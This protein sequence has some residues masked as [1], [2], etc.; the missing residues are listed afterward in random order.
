MGLL[1]SIGSALS[2][3]I[4]SVCSMA[5]SAIGSI[6]SSISSFAT[7]IAPKLVTVLK[8]APGVISTVINVAQTIGILFNIFKPED[9]VEDLG[10]KAIQAADKGIT[11]D[12][13]DDNDDY[14]DALR[15]FQT[16]PER[17]AEIDD[18]VKT[19]A[20]LGLVTTGIEK[21]LD[22]PEGSTGGI[23]LLAASAPEHF[24]AERLSNMI[25]NSSDLSN[26][27][28]YFDGDLNVTDAM[29]IEKQLVS[30]EQ[31]FSPELSVQ[32]VNEQLDSVSDT[33][34]AFK[35]DSNQ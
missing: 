11:I 19:V 14:M 8:M 4:S 33:V 20:G 13:Y 32:Q 3:G 5:S 12:D 34:Q 22:L 16:D 23:F 31:V 26:V 18:V 9:R 2:S 6:G 29:S 7:N 27:I 30:S 28:E 35:A 21:K 15:D 10:D 17:S 24:T 1:S 25:E